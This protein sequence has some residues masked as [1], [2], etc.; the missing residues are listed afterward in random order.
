MYDVVIVG[1]GISGLYTAYLLSKHKSL[2]ILIIE[3]YECGGKISTYHDDDMTVEAG[4]ARFNETHLLLLEL[5][6]DLGLSS[7]IHKIDCKSHYAF[8]SLYNLMPILSKVIDFSYT[9][10]VNDLTQLSFLDYAKKIVSKEEVEHIQHS[11]DYSSELNIMNAKDMIRL[12][13]QLSPDRNF[14]SL[15]GGLSQII[16]KLTE[17]LK[18]TIVKDEVL[19][20]WHNGQFFIKTKRHIYQTPICVM[21][22][23]VYALNAISFFKPLRSTLDH[24]KMSP[25]CRI[26]SITNPILLKNMTV[27]NDLRMIIP[28]SP[29]LIMSSY[30]DGEYAKK[31]KRVYDNEGIRGVNKKLHHHMEEIGLNIPLRHTKIFYWKYGVGYWG[32]GANSKHISETILQ[33]YNMNLFICGE[34][35]SYD[36]QQWMEGALDTSRQ[37]VDKIKKII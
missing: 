23:P 26:Y 25:L 22:V 13:F 4:A 27:N 35:Y 7:N 31:W 14:Y 10:V 1:G 30:T 28:I 20:L 19:N 29:T 3:K 8:R 37:I 2:N 6:D 16:N 17:R 33:P 15:H 34:N 18:V 11:Y 32:V 24:I 21:A 36:Y 5:L 12:L 9:D